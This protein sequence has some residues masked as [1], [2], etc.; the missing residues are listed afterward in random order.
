MHN[1]SLYIVVTVVVKFTAI[2]KIK[3]L[4]FSRLVNLQPAI[5]KI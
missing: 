1:H 4:N 2:C 3:R 5:S